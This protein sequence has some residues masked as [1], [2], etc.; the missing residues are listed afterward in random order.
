MF[1]Y[2]PDESSFVILPRPCSREKKKKER[3]KLASGPPVQQPPSWLC[4]SHGGGARGRHVG[5]RSG[6]GNLRVSD[7]GILSL[8]ELI[9]LEN[10]DKERQIANKTDFKKKKPKKN[11]T[12]AWLVPAPPPVSSGP[13]LCTAALPCRWTCTGPRSAPCRSAA[14]AP[15][16]WSWGCRCRNPDLGAQT[17]IG[18][19][20]V[21][22]VQPSCFNTMVPGDS[23]LWINEIIHWHIKIN[24]I[25]NSSLSIIGSMAQW[26]TTGKQLVLKTAT[27]DLRHKWG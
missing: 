7:V 1:S 14:A 19:D 10:D 4:Y 17:I 24:T 21:S 20:N 13:C 22:K 18:S 11:Q 25:F 2:T 8:L 23:L 27:V 5:F 12:N 26:D 3:K 6:V 16:G 15:A 9:P